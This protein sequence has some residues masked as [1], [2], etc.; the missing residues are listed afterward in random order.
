MSD[1]NMISGL[2]VVIRDLSKLKITKVKPWVVYFTYC[3]SKFFIK[4]VENNCSEY[5]G[6]RYDYDLYFRSNNKAVLLNSTSVFN[7]GIEDIK[8]HISQ[9]NNQI[10]KRAFCD[11]VKPFIV[12][13]DERWWE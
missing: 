9:P 5:Y 8:S 6:G 7:I 12:L 13:M 3:N 10:D 2:E 1:Y 11:I 4:A